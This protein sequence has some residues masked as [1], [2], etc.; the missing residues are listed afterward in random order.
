MDTAT[1]IAQTFVIAALAGW[2]TLGVKDNIQHPDMNRSSVIKVLQMDLLAEMYPDDFK[3]IAQRRV[4]NPALHNTVYRLIVIAELVAAIL[5]WIGAV[6]LAFATFG[7]ANA[8]SARI[9]GLIGTISFTSVW[10]GFS[11]PVIILVTGTAMK[12]P[13]TLISNWQSG[14]PRQ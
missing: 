9:A 4:V 3:Q 6:W 12:E 14:E 10:P 2:M 7:V 13:R 8:E 1:L 5:L 11:S